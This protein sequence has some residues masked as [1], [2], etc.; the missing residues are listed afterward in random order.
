MTTTESL[1]VIEG[2]TLNGQPLA[3]APE[4]D[5]DSYWDQAYCFYCSRA[6]CHRG[7]HGD[8]EALGLA[9]RDERGDYHPTLLGVYVKAYADQYV[10]VRDPETYELTDFY[11]EVQ[12]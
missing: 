11:V 10:F 5:T 2:V 7:E 8:A 9:Y 12:A 1:T 4:F 6:T 3:F